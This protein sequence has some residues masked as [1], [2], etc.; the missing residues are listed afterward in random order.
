M[1]VGVD[2][3]SEVVSDLLL[4]SPHSLNAS[5]NTSATSELSLPSGSHRSGVS[6]RARKRKG[7]Q[8]EASLDNSLSLS[9]LSDEEDGVRVCVHVC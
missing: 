3:G 8:A 2:A 1:C 6:P 5:L 4:S 9:D 7:G